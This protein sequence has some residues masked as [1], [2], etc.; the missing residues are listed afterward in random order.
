MIL[1]GPTRPIEDSIAAQFAYLS[2]L[3]PNDAALK[4]ATAAALRF[5][6]AVENPTLKPTDIIDVPLSASITG[7]YFLD[8]RGYHPER[9]AATLSIPM[10]VLQGDRDYQVTTRD[11]FS[12]WKTALA[13]KKNATLKTYPTLSHAFATGST[14]PSPAD[15]AT[16]GHVD[17]AVIEDIARF[18]L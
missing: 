18:L 16:A 11:D 9:V 8:V 14:T 12:G 10:L 15:Y 1:A 6:A 4:Q 5:K 13:H 2:S 17:E 3:S 7:E